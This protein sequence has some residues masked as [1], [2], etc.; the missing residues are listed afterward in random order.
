MLKL[1]SPA[2][3][4]LV[5]A[6][7]CAALVLSALWWAARYP[8]PGLN[9]AAPDEAGQV[10]VSDA[11][12]RQVAR[13]AAADP[14]IFRQ[15]SEGLAFPAEELHPLYIRGGAP[16]ALSAWYV[17]VGALARMFEAGPVRVDL[18]DG[19]SLALTPGRKGLANQSLEFWLLIGAASAVFLI[20][21]WVWALR[22]RDWA[23]ATYALSALGLSGSVYTTALYAARE[24]GAG[25]GF[26][27]AVMVVNYIASQLGFWGLI[28]M[29]MA[30][31]KTVIRPRLWHL[32][33]PAVIVGGAAAGTAW[34]EVK[35]VFRSIFLAFLIMVGLVGAQAWASRRDPVARAVL[36]WMGLTILLGTA[37]GVLIFV[38]PRLGGGPLAASLG[39]GVIPIVLTHGG[40]AIGVGRHRLFNLD[41]WAYRIIAVAAAA[42]ALLVLDGLLIALLHLPPRAALGI[43]LAAVAAGYLPLRALLWRL[44][45]GKVAP[46]DSRLFQKAAEVAFTPGA[47]AR[48]DAWRG[49]LAD[50]FDVL[51]MEAAPG[52]EAPAIRADGL[53]LAIPPACGEGALVLRYPGK[54]RR[55][56]N[57]GHLSLARE[58]AAFMD[59]AEAARDAYR[60]GVVEERGRIAQD[61][62][63]DVGARLLTSLHRPEVDLVRADVRE[64][65]SDIRTIVAGLTGQE[66]RLADMMD[67]LRRESGERLEDAGVDLDWPPASQP[68]PDRTLDH[69]VYRNL[70]SA[71]REVVSNILRHSGAK[72]VQARAWLEGGVLRLTMSD[73]G[74][75]LQT[76]TAG[77]RQGAGLA[78]L[79]RRIAALGG[80]LTL[81]PADPG[82]RVDMSVPMQP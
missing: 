35:L 74:I 3:L 44:M 68:W 16:A 62:H 46:V 25:G 41:R 36:G 71:L 69:A 70:R 38:L 54:G 55:L 18:P 12:G 27:W 80:T 21:A 8:D 53:E 64:A 2:G 19:S 42:F 43:S 7:L 73:D 51:E 26:L 81:T 10:A 14:V 58:L 30:F 1:R 5:A 13:L 31:P 22:P 63:D 66:A 65:M 77:E 34:L 75:G 82:V 29:F 72:R 50:L 79:S 39:L 48:Q 23:A 49:L 59:R 67:E 6:H 9:F 24:A 76:K 47:G 32:V 20:G 61:L 37:I 17:K 40:V 78:N 11:A 52:A 60:R 4:L 45:A 33:I 15:G 56:F 57:A 28:A